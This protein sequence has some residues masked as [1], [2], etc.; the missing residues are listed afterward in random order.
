MPRRNSLEVLY[1]ML[2]LAR[3]GNVRK[4]QF[5]YGVS[6]S[7]ARLQGYLGLLLEIGAV[8]E[9]SG[10]YNLTEKG[11]KMLH[12]MEELREVLFD[13]PPFPHILSRGEP[14]KH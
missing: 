2:R 3:A 1:D 12:V 10:Y 9:K 4:S 14:K 5:M 6:L 13:A 8:E 11:R 7:Y